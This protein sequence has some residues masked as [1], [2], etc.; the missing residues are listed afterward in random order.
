[1]LGTK[2]NMAIYDWLKSEKLAISIVQP[3]LNEKAL[4]VFACGRNDRKIRL[5]MRMMALSVR[6]GT[7]LHDTRENLPLQQ[8]QINYVIYD[9]L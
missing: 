1:M 2:R 6:M 5:D 3:N 4:M 8:E 9:T 7:Y